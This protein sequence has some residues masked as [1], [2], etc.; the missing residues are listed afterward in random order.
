MSPSDVRA[1]REAAGDALQL[2]AIAVVAVFLYVGGCG[3]PVYAAT[4]SA[5]PGAY[6]EVAFVI[7]VGF[8]LL[9]FLAAFMARRLKPREPR[10]ADAFLDHPDVI[11]ASRASGERMRDIAHVV[12]PVGSLAFA[13]AL[14]AHAGGLL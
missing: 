11:A 5:A 8:V 4:A 12:F 6:G 2:L 1:R 10:E 9:A 14:L 7:V 3:L 13:G